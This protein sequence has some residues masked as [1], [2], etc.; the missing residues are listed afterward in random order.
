MR[1]VTHDFDVLELELVDVSDVRVEPKHRQ[2]ARFAC[3]LETCLVEM[4][5]V[6]VDVA[7]VPDEIAN[8]EPRYLRDHVR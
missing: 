3:Q 2:G 6:E 8:L 1:F 7:A 5:Q 4:V